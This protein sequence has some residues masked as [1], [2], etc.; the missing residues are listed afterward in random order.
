[1]FDQLCVVDEG[2]SIYF[3]PTEGAAAIFGKVTLSLYTLSGWV[4]GWMDGWL[5]GWMAGWMDG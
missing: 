2:H 1:M 5:A 4:A 3:G